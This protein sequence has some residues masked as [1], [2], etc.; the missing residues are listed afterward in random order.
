MT[1][2][3]TRCSTWRLYVIVDPSACGSR[4]IAEVTAAAIRGGADVIQLRD[5]RASD[6]TLAKE[7][8]RLLPLTR[9]AR[10]PLIINDRPEACLAAGA[11]GLH[12]GQDDLPVEE[13]RRL[14]GPG[15]LIGRSTHSIEQ[16]LQAQAQPVDYIGLGPIFPTPTKPDYGSIGPALIAQVLASSRVPVVCIGGIEE[17]NVRTVLEAGATCVAVIRA[18]CAAADPESA[19]RTLKRIIAQSSRSST[20][21]PL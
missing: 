6:A 8:E 19:A 9:A 12:L 18:V 15:C 13:A 20:T 11:D 7:A 10:I 4:D 21:V 1:L 3:A 16:A 14:L 2:N 5:K 17:G